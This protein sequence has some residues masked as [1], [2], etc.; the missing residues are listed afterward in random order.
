[1]ANRQEMLQPPG[2]VEIQK[3]A[4]TRVF[5]PGDLIN[6][7][8][9]GFCVLFILRSLCRPRGSILDS[10]AQT[11]E[12]MN[13]K[14]LSIIILLIIIIT[15]ASDFDKPMGILS[16]KWPRSA[17]VFFETL[18]NTKCVYDYR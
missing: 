11:S 6:L 15:L 12:I 4:G 9:G 13:I 10:S 8:C 1:M 2:P 7:Y 14:V 3:G 16:T 18:K 5:R 17:Q